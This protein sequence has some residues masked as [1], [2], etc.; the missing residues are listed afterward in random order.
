MNKELHKTII[1]FAI[2]PI[3]LF[4]ML[5]IFFYIYNI[6]HIGLF[7]SARCMYL[8]FLICYS[9]YFILYAITKKTWKAT[10]ILAIT[11]FIFSIINQL[12]IAYTNEPV[13]LSDVLYLSSSNEIFGIVR[14]TL[15]DFLKINILTTLIYLMI[16]IVLCVLAYKNNLTLSNKKIRLVSIGIPVI[17]LSILFTP[18][19]FTKDIFLNTFFEVNKR[20]DYAR[21]TTN[22]FYYALYGVIPG[23]YGQMLENRI[24]KPKDYDETV[25]QHEI[26]QASNNKDRFLGKPN[27]I[28]L[29]SES[30]WDIDQ[31][32]EVKFN[33][34][35]TPNFKK[36][37]SE[38][39]FFN[40]ISP[41]YGGVTAN[42]EFEFFTGA[43]LMYFNK[44]YIPFMQLYRND[45][46]YSKPSI[47]SELENNGYNTKLLTCSTD[48]LFH[49]G[50]FYNYLGIN[51]CEFMTDAN[52]DNIK[53]QYISDETVVNKIIDEFE[54]K[55]SDEK[56]FY[57]ALTI[58]AHMPYLISK[59]DNYD[60]YVESSN[61]TQDMNDTLTSYAQGIHDADKQ[62]Q[63]LYNYIKTLDEPT[64]IVF[65]GDHLPYLN[66]KEGEDVIEN[67]EF[68]NTKN[69]LKNIYRKYN[70]QS[71]I[72]ANFQLQEEK[73]IK[74]VGPDLLGAYVLNK[75][76]IQTSNYYKWLY[77]T[78]NTLGASN[79]I[80]SSDKYGNLYYTNKLDGDMKEIYNLRENIQYKYF[81]K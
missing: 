80:I 70:T 46:F 50:R 22:T 20:Q 23:M 42:V 57:M 28:V 54:N 24:E 68:F 63:R 30:F 8:S 26:T 18:I 60:V 29:F 11:F 19:S 66:T 33:T 78:I 9:L 16:L 67:L 62:L 52:E 12:K 45:S 40:M 21:S 79:Y 77:S 17:I 58:Q 75:M 76:D 48:Q 43:N 51:D 36:L 61:L 5:D 2:I 25:I 73:E 69:E 35:V 49:C 38:G 53:G 65:Y 34:T 47:I 27:V 7:V 15:F 10:S 74:Y 44:G 14:D 72:L 56:L 13:V 64:I 55:K 81:I 71:L 39:I 6:G 31:L 37:Q 3:V 41:S 59:Y 1:S 4:I 32:D